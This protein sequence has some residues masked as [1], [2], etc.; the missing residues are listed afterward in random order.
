MWRH[1]RLLLTLVLI[2]VAG[3]S[4]F[5]LTQHYQQLFPR[6]IIEFEQNLYFTCLV[7]N[8]LLFILIRKLELADGE[9]TLLVGGL[10]IQFAGPAANFALVHLTQ[11]SGVGNVLYTYVGPLCTL[12]MLSTWFIAVARVPRTVRVPELGS[13]AAE[14]TATVGRRP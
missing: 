13:Q 7:L 1:I 3:V 9:L 10:G 12:G 11:G 5:S 4:W 8:T 14:M 6:F 2:L